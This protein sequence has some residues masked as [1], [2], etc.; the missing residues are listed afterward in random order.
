MANT[1][2]E[3]LQTKG[4]RDVIRI[5]NQTRPKLFDLAVRKPDVLYSKVV[6][7][8]ERCTVEWSELVEEG[9]TVSTDGHRLVTGLSG[10]VVRVIKD[11]GQCSDVYCL[12]GH[13]DSG[14]NR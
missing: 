4:Y 3:C 1:M 9:A 13:A 11:I 2:A 8:D 10:D 12:K 7:I 6:E 5:G 14:C